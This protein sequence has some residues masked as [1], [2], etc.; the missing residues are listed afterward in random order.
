MQ[1]L[2]VEKEDNEIKEPKLIIW[3]AIIIF[4][5]SII[6]VAFCFKFMVDNIS[7]IT[8]SSTVFIIFVS[9]ILLPI[10]GNAAK[11]ITVVTVACKDKIS[12]AINVVI[13]SSIQI[14]LLVLLF[15]IVFSWIIGQDCIMLYFNN[16][17]IAVLFVAMLL[18]NYFIQ[19][20][21]SSKFSF[22]YR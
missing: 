4:G 13:G 12:L 14:A 3:G 16:F 6:L 11:H 22:L 15:V 19:D 10:V 1:D 2:N 8:A 21:K 9:L 5:F 17:L 7:N 18:I 20:G